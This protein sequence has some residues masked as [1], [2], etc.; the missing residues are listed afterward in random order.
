[1]D[2]KCFKFFF[3]LMQVLMRRISTEIHGI[4]EWIQFQ[5]PFFSCKDYLNYCAKCEQTWCAIVT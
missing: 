4:L 5:T 3:Y 2:L 1:M